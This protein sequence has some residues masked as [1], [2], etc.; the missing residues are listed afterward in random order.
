[1]IDWLYSASMGDP[2]HSVPVTVRYSDRSVVF[3]MTNQGFLHAIDVSDNG[4]GVQDRELFAFMPR[5][6]LKNVPALQARSYTG[7]HV[8]GLDGAI[9]RWHDDTLVRDGLVN[10]GERVVLYFGM[11]RGG[12]A[13]YALDVSD[14]SA[15]KLLWT[16][17]PST[18]G[19]S[20]LGQ[21]WSRM[22]LVNMPWQGSTRKMLV[23]G[24]GYD[25]VHDENDSRTRTDIGN[26]IYFVDPDTGA[27]LWSIAGTGAQTNVPAMQFSIPA[28]LRIID[29]DANGIADRIYAGDLG[30]QLWRVKLDETDFGN[31]NG[32]QVTRMAD[33]ADDSPQGDRRFFYAPTA[34]HSNTSVDKYVGIS[35][36][37]GNRAKPLGFEVQDRVYAL[38]D[39]DTIT[40]LDLTATDEFDNSQLVDLT[41]PGA[42]PVQLK[43]DLAKSHGWY[44]DL[45]PGEKALS[46]IVAFEGQ[47]LFTTYAP[48]MDSSGSA[49][50]V[51]CSITG[52]TGR[53]YTVN[54]SNA[55][56][57]TIIDQADSKGV[58]GESRYTLVQSDGILGPPV[59]VFPEGE[60]A[61]DVYVDKTKVGTIDQRLRKIFWHAR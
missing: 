20:R 40:T 43:S 9:S 18:S 25:P 7:S 32:L 2:M 36:A 8:Y 49:Q 61:V 14:V 29:V 16:I 59:V 4:T 48:S 51:Q 6:L 3:T 53:F 56:A 26:A 10:P 5:R 17:D 27:L 37:S 60:G 52:S 23:F 22:S 50:S 13:Y 28:D 1:M 21:S 54:Q 19:F 31:A 24:G 41:I 45:A 34:Y 58:E 12:T 47:L 46:Q 33:F 30:G 39:R 55:S 38:R 11:R 44:I 15:P 42:D 57:G 35:I